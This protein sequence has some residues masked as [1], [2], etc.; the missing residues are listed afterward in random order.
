MTENKSEVESLRIVCA[1]VAV[2]SSVIY[3]FLLVAASSL[4]KIKSMTEFDVIRNADG[5]MYQG[6]AP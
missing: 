2:F 5:Q 6:V 3:I 4:I 1:V